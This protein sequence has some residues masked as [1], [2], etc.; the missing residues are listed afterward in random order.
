V[1]SGYGFGAAHWMVQKEPWS[2]GTISRLVVS[3]E[4][5]HAS[6]SINLEGYDVEPI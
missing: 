6:F 4:S 1:G 3:V 5:I 2:I